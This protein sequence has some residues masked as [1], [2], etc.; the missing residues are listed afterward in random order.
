[1]ASSES[2]KKKWKKKNNKN[3]TVQGLGEDDGIIDGHKTSN[4]SIDGVQ[5]GDPVTSGKF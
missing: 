4:N 1:M 2:S 3:K 5:D